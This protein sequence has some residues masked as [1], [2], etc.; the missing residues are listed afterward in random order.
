MSHKAITALTATVASALAMGLLAGCPPNAYHVLTLMVTPLDGGTIA[1][2]PDRA[3]YFAGTEVT[4]EAIPNEGYEFQRWV[5]TGMNTT[6]N[7]TNKRVYADDTIAAEFIATGDGTADEGEGE[8]VPSGDVVKD[9]DFEEDSGDWTLVSLTGMDIVC[10]YG[11][12]GDAEGL[13]SVSGSHWAWLGNNLIFNYES[14]TLFQEITMPVSDDARLEFYLAMPKS[15]MPFTFRVLFDATV[16]A[17]YTDGDALL[18]GTYQPVSIDVSSFADGRT[19]VLTF[20]Y[21]STGITGDESAVFV[22]KVSI[23]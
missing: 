10:D 4:L 14:A 13:T 23:E 1:I 16:V 7:P 20:L 18:Y 22:D 9:G 5:G 19:T 6:I 21:S 11:T 2:D 15:D 12:C 17:E 8:N 3:T